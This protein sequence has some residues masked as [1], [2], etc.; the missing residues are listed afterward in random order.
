MIATI[1]S[2]H[3]TEVKCYWVKLPTTDRGAAQ[4]GLEMLEGCRG[5]SEYSMEHFD[6]DL[7]MGIGVD[8]GRA[9]VGQVGY[10]NN[11]R[12]TAIGDVVNTAKRV[13]DLTKEAGTHLLVPNA[14][15]ERVQDRFRFG[16]E[17]TTDIRGKAGKHQVSEVLAAT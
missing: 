2:D 8:S 12:L 6:F 11:T 13:Q 1:I 3:R 7:R 4:C 17:L 14:V 16:R 5:L 10:Y 9:V 15:R